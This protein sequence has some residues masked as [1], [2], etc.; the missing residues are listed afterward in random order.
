MIFDARFELHA[1]GKNRHLIQMFNIQKV[2][3][4]SILISSGQM[5]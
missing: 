2:E 1:C 5:T 4:H 3:V